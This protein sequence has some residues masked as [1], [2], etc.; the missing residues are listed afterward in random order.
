MASVR[1]AN[2]SGPPPTA[3]IQSSDDTVSIEMTDPIFPLSHADRRKSN[4]MNSY[5]E[6]RH[7]TNPE[8]EQEAPAETPAPQS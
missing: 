5:P 6:F 7:A 2:R 8:A 4:A 3:S 1:H